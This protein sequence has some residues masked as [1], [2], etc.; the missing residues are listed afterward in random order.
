MREMRLTRIALSGN[1]MRG[2]HARGDG[3]TSAVEREGIV[4]LVKIGTR[5]GGAADDRLCTEAS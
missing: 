3:Y 4:P 5:G 2:N 1:V